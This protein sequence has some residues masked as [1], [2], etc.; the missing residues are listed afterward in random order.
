MKIK[1][2]LIV[3]AALFIIELLND[4]LNIDH[5]LNPEIEDVLYVLLGV[6]IIRLV[7]TSIQNAVKRKTQQVEPA[8]QKSRTMQEIEREMD[9][10]EEILDVITKATRENGKVVPIWNIDCKEP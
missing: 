2:I 9:E 4:N 8:S 1:P 7:Y 6:C 5:L 10:I 3:I